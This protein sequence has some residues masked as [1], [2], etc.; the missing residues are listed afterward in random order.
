MDFIDIVRERRS[1]RRYTDRMPDEGQ[2][3]YLLECARLAPSAVNRQPCHYHVV[4]SDEMRA[5]V[6][7]SYNREW[8][9]TAPLYIIVCVDTQTAWTRQVDGKPHGDIDAA[10]ATEH[11][12][13]AAT[14]LGLGTCW[15][16]NFKPDVLREALQLAPHMEP[17]A[18]IPVGYADSDATRATT[19]K[20]PD[21][22][23]TVW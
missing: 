12:C 16:C 13:L 22:V 11:L 15:V 7:A 10:I 6:Q 5:K 20:S 2:I 4:K 1:V 8:F 3:K 19:R 14:A 21:E 9:A 18:I 17:V 23:V